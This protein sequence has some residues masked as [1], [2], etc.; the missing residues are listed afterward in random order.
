[1]HKHTQREETRIY[2]VRQDA[3]VIGTEERDLY[4]IYKIL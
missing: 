3:Y 1:M 4:M 2:E